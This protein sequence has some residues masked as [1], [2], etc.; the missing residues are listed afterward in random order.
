M[1]YKSALRC[2]SWLAKSRLEE[3]PSHKE[4]VTDTVY[5]KDDFE[6]CYKRCISQ[7]GILK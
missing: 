6:S 7:Y 4:L 2:A 5:K 1:C 3:D